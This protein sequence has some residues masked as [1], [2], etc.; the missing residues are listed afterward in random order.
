VATARATQ[1]QLRYGDLGTAEQER[2]RLLQQNHSLTEEVAKL[3]LLSPIAG[4]VATPRLHDLSGTYLDEGAPVVELIDDSALRARVYV[5]EFAMHDLHLGA[6][7]R[8]HVQSRLLPVAG[9]L[10]SISADWV[11]LDPSLAE[12]E[13]LTGINPPRF[14][15]AEAW[16]DRAG[17]LLPGMTGIAKI[18][19][20]RRSLAGLGLR[21]VR[22]LVARRVW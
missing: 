20:G 19:V 8:L 14:Y 2:I 5:P 10:H 16:L 9:V 6:P 15:L 21:F 17:D 13:Q 3:Q 18:Q 11:P 4:V 7:V 12:K 22:D 1:S